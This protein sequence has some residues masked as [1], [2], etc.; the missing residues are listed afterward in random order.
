VGR[1]VLDDSPRWGNENFAAS[2]R[3][4]SER[5]GMKLQPFESGKRKCALE[6]P[7]PE[8]SDAEANGQGKPACGGQVSSVHATAFPCFTKIL[9][10]CVHAS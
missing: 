2:P 6:Y 10:I 3:K 1:Q 7:R 5:D 4:F 8:F 9:K